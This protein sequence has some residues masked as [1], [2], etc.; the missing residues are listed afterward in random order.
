MNRQRRVEALTGYA[1][2]T[3]QLIGFVLLVLIPLI[4]V[5]IYSFHTFDQFQV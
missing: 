4:N 3:P 5:F 2:V 1:F